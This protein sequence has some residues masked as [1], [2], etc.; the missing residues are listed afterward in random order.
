MTKI[1]N[2]IG[3]LPQEIGQEAFQLI[4]GLPGYSGD[5]AGDVAY[6]LQAAAAILIDDD[7]PLYPALR[8]LLK[9]GRQDPTV[10]K[11]DWHHEAG[12]LNRS[13]SFYCRTLPE[14][15]ALAADERGGFGEVTI[16]RNG[17]LLAVVRAGEGSYHDFPYL[18]D[19]AD[20]SAYEP[21]IVT[22]QAIREHRPDY[23]FPVEPQE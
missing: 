15:L 21:G 20:I 10:K 1:F 17:T 4:D 8:C 13:G 5:Y 12:D 9:T 14:A 11:F 2:H 16:R 18:D 7:H 6:L 23:R 19:V 3:L 22:T